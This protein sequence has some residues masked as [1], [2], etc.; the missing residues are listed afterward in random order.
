MSLNI[1]SSLTYSYP[2]AVQAGDI[3]FVSYKPSTNSFASNSTLS[4]KMT[5]NTEFLIPERSYIKFNL[6]P[7]AVSTLNPQGASACFSQIQDIIGGLSVPLQRNWNVE[8]NV[9]LQSD[10]SERKQITVA[11]EQFT[12]SSSATG[13]VTA[14]DTAIPIVM[15]FISSVDFAGKVFPLAVISSGWQIDYTLAPDATVVV[16]GSYTIS[17]FEIVA[18]MIK[19]PS[20]Y[21]R[22]INEGLASGSSLKMPVSLTK[23]ITTG[24]TNNNSQSINLNI[25]YLSSI[26]SLTMVQKTTNAHITSAKLT[27]YVI[28]IDGQRFPR[29]KQIY[30]NLEGIYQTLAGYDTK[31]NSIG[32][33]DATYQV[34]QHYS[35]K[36]SPA[37]ASGIPTANGI[38]SLD[39]A[40]STAPASTDVLIAMINYDALLVISNGVVQL[41]S[42]V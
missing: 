24:L 14:V 32:L 28:N 10:T 42:D 12:N 19:P 16:A 34:F 11:C 41:S 4:V 17:D 33:G 20:N 6:T 15:P 38:V 37:F 23:T 35:F 40:C 18:C 22:E 5:S 27:S 21:M 29:N 8:R 39:L 36:S 3:N 25:G 7:S 31:I 30:T 9:I 26:N 1:H 2:E 13:T